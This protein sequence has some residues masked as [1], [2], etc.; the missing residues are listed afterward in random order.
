MSTPPARARAEQLLDW[1][2]ET[3]YEHEETVRANQVSAILSYGEEI[4][5]ELAPF[6]IHSAD[7]ATWTTDG[8]GN[9][10]FADD[11]PSCDCGLSA[12]LPPTGSR[13]GE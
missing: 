13:R 3:D 12:L 4:R 6:T 5:R 8:R 10:V 1:I 11:N 2:L 7:C 9:T